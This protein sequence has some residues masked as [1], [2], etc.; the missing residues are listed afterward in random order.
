MTYSEV[1]NIIEQMELPYAYLSFPEKKAPK[2]PYVI[3][4]YPNSDDL[5]ADNQNYAKIN[6]LMIELY[7]ANKDF[8]T[9]SKVEQVLIDNHIPYLKN[10]IY[11]D[12]EQMY[13][14][15]YE[16]EVVING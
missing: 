14:I 3:Y 1:V 12:S 8:E 2:L 16:S 4:H 5:M 7:T 15:T 9:E 10:E 13:E 11:I 6:N